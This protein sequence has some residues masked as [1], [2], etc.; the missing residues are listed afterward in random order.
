MVRTEIITS[1]NTG[2]FGVIAN[3]LIHTIGYIYT[4]TKKQGAWN[5]IYTAI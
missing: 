4:L 5:T 2:K 1:K 3:F